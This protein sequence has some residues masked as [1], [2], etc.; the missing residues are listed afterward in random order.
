MTLN[1]ANADD[2]QKTYA[3]LALTPNPAG[4][5]Q[6][7]L[8]VMFL[9]NLQASAGG[10]GGARFHNYT[11]TITK[12]D[13][14]IETQGPF[15]SDDVSNAGFYYTPTTIGNYTFVFKYPGE[16]T[17]ATVGPGGSSP[18]TTFGPS[19]SRPVTLVV[20]QNAVPE[21]FGNP[22]PTNYWL[23]PLNAQNYLW[24]SIS[25]NWLM[26]S[27]DGTGRQFDQG[28]VYIPAGAAKVPDSAHVLW[29]EPI[30]FGGLVGGEFGNIQYTDG[31]SYEQFFKPPVVIAGRL[32]YNTIQAEEPVTAI[33][34]SSITCL[35]LR[36]GENIFTIPNATLSFGQIYNYVSP[37]QAGALA[38]LWETRGTTWRM[39]DA[40]TGN[41][42]LSIAG[43][44]SGTTLLDNTFYGDSK[45]GPGDILVYSLNANQKSLVLW[46][47]S[48][49]IPK[50]GDT[51]TNYWQWRPY[52]FVG[53]TLNATGNTTYPGSFGPTVRNSNGI[54]WNATLQDFP[55]GGT[56]RQIGYDNKI[57]VS[58]GTG[59]Q[60]VIFSFP[61]VST[62]VCYSMT[63]GSKLWG[64]TTID[65]RTQLP[66]NATGIFS[67]GISSNRQIGP[68]DICP[69][70]C[71]ETMQWFT[72]N[73]QTGQFM[74][75][76]DPLTTNDFGFYNWESKLLT[77][78]GYLYNWGYDGSIHAYNL[79]TGK[80]LW[81]FSSGD[82]ETATP[83]GVWPF[84]NGLTI[85]DGK[86]IG[87][88]S[89]H[90]N[91]V[92]PLFQGEGLYVLNYQTGQQLWNFTGW[93]EQGVIADNI[94][95]AHN[96]YD[97]QIYAF[98]KG[99]SATTVSAQPAVQT[100]GSAV[101]IQGTVSD[102]SPGAKNMV[103]NGVINL[104]PLVDDADQNQYMEYLYE[105][106]AFPT[107]CRGV[108]VHL[109]AVD[110]NHVIKDL[111]YVT[112]DING[113]FKMMWT[114]DATG[115]YTIVASFDGSNSYWSS[116][117][118]T[119]IGIAA[120]PA[121]SVSP[122]PTAAP[123]PSGIVTP[124]PPVN[125]FNL[126]FSFCQLFFSSLCNGST[127][128]SDH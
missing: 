61:Y 83:Y 73:L 68:G 54:M 27:W 104:V 101:M 94:Y 47:S 75:K 79:T 86:L 119:A 52:Q 74:Y 92:E 19:Q 30:T 124:T 69:L 71:K 48:Q 85:A 70:W 32:Y 42:I 20:Q 39:F 81:Q 102:Q 105:Q 46:N 118:E 64:P 57:Y 7:V 65:T 8:V 11:V 103:A 40:W 56:I 9:S 106:Q 109:R 80:A 28:S 1:S 24:Q 14:S 84:Y 6:K 2:T 22:V 89:D 126:E 18:N 10:T 99:P 67:S 98:G 93:F 127:R 120:A 44:P 45:R 13:G 117:A 43:V 60:G 25:S 5:N 50:L 3:F 121:G 16:F 97:N 88:T 95:V 111:G 108:Q 29:A 66:L 31:R 122:P 112:S 49:C 72:W 114:P 55:T 77:P 113:F 26:A 110:S 37:N 115:E 63:D 51:G 90:G 59:V 100:K 34:F 116:S 23:R 58:N 35:D 123:T 53:I 128:S 4:T 125:Y 41:Y 38:Y 33:N 76:T 21:T 15:I 62:W 12:P 96:C 91:G 36:T 17:P 78:D 87:Q 82:A 107:N